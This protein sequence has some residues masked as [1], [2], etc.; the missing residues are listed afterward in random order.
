MEQGN[1]DFSQ[2]LPG[3][4]GTGEARALR[5]RRRA[6]AQERAGDV[7]QNGYAAVKRA[8]VELEEARANESQYLA[9]VAMGETDEA[10]SPVKVATDALGKAETNYELAMRTADALNEQ[11]RTAERELTR[12]K[13]NLEDA[14]KAAVKNDQAMQQLVAEFTEVH[15][16]YLDLKRL[17][18]RLVGLVPLSRW[19]GDDPSRPDPASVQAWRMALAALR[20]DADAALPRLKR[21]ER[22][23][24]TPSPMRSVSSR[25]GSRGRCKSASAVSAKNPDSRRG[26]DLQRFLRGPAA[27]KTEMGCLG[28]NHPQ[29]CLGP[30]QRRS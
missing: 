21:N 22:A 4:R 26:L 15:G 12:A 14:V 29:G 9:S 8:G 11:E 19:G 5:R 13:S 27:G 7:R 23:V 3:S 2:R 18:D 24:F 30:P 10:S 17:L 20:T 28:V 25:F 16:R 6:G 1:Q